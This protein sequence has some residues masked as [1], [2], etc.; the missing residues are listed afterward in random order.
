MKLKRNSWTLFGSPDDTPVLEVYSDDDPGTLKSYWTLGLDE[1]GTVDPL[2]SSHWSAD[3]ETLLGTVTL[4]SPGDYLPAIQQ[5]RSMM[6]CNQLTGELNGYYLIHGIPVMCALEAQYWIY[7]EPQFRDDQ[8]TL[9]ETAR[10]HMTY[11]ENFCAL[12]DHAEH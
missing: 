4:E 12:W 10:A 5:A 1:Y 3:G 9:T 11:L 2:E 7:A 8:G 6:D